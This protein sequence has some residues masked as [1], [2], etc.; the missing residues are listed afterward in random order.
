MGREIVPF[1][2]ILA[3]LSQMVV[4]NMPQVYDIT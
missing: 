3:A 1:I 2:N 4:C